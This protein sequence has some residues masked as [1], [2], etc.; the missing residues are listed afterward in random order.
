M[1]ALDNVLKISGVVCLTTVTLFTG[2]VGVKVYKVVNSFSGVGESL[3]EASKIGVD[4]LSTLRKSIS[5]EDFERFR[6]F[7]S[8]LGRFLQ[9][10]NSL[11]NLSPEDKKNVSPIIVNF[12][13]FL[14]KLLDNL[15]KSSEGAELVGK[16]SGLVGTLNGILRDFREN[17]F[18]C[19]IANFKIPK[20]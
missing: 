11:E 6:Y 13:E 12:V 1:N 19:R 14:N 3:N 9:E 10:P 8:S 7:C 16:I 2:V 4:F 17:G 5:S 15:N 18:G 20:K